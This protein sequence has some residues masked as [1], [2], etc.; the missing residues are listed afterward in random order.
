MEHGGADLV[1]GGVEGGMPI[2]DKRRSCS[3]GVRT[4]ARINA[5]HRECT[6]SHGL[7]RLIRW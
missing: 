1:R 3:R 6:C 5:R 2:L 4:C 7:V